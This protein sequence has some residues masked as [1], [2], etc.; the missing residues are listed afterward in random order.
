MP[1]IS[2]HWIL[3]GANRLCD[4]RDNLMATELQDVKEVKIPRWERIADP[5]NIEKLLDTI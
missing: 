5:R 2:M 3:W 1:L 4:V